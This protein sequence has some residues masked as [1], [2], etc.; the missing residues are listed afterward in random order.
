MF[1]WGRADYEDVYGTPHFVQWCY[2]VRFERHTVEKLRAHFI[3]WGEYNR[4]DESAW[5]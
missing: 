3:Q 5:Q 4:S 1:V 2:N